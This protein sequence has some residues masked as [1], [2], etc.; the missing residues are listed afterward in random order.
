MSVFVVEFKDRRTNRVVGKGVVNFNVNM[1]RFQFVE[2]EYEWNVSVED[3]KMKI[4][5]FVMKWDYKRV[6][7]NAVLEKEREREMEK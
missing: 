7:N 5:E 4:G 1:N 2:G 6:I 3:R